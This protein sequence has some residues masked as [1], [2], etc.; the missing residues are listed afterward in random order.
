ML[1]MFRNL[2]PDL[3]FST[4][5]DAGWDTVLFAV[6]HRSKSA[7]ATGCRTGETT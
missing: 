4:L 2:Q 3:V 5:V 1:L 6:M 7:K